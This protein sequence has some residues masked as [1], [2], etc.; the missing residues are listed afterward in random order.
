M[1]QHPASG[2]MEAPVEIGHQIETSN[3]AYFRHGYDCE[4]ADIRR[5]YEQA[6]ID[7]WNAATDIDWAARSKATAA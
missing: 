2:M 5:L 4:H 3:V 6:K 7:Q 1:H